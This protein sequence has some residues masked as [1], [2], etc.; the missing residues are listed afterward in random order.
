ME[1]LNKNRYFQSKKI[2]IAVVIIVLTLWIV[3]ALVMAWCI[4]NIAFFGF[5]KE[6]IL[7]TL[8]WNPSKELYADLD[9]ATQKQNLYLVRTIVSSILFYIQHA[10]ISYITK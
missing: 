7:Q 3:F 6:C 5:E 10:A 4:L 2:R 8:K 9:S 1:R